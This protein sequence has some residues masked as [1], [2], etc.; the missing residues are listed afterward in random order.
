LLGRHF[1]RKETDDGAISHVLGAVGFQLALVSA[2]DM[3]GDIR[4]KRCLSHRRTSGKNN[5]IRSLQPT[6]SPI[7]IRETTRNP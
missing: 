7:D 5:K 3:V 2:G 6:H 1:E 4:G